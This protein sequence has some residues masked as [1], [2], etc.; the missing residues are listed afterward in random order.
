MNVANRF[1]RTSANQ[2]DD[3]SNNRVN[4]EGLWFDVNEKEGERGNKGWQS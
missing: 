4:F 3:E 2:E 1:R